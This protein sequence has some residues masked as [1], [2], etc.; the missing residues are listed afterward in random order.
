FMHPLISQQQ[1]PHGDCYLPFVTKA[2]RAGPVWQVGN[3]CLIVTGIDAGQLQHGPAAAGGRFQRSLM[4]AGTCLFKTDSPRHVYEL[5][6][7]LGSKVAAS[8]LE[9]FVFGSKMYLLM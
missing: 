9:I 3:S 1:Q 7:W 6:R 5:P 8:A 4:A 2:C